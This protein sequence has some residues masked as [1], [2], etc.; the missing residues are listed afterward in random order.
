MTINRS[1]MEGSNTNQLYRKIL[2]GYDGSENANRALGRA[3]ELVIFFRFG[4]K[5]LSE[6][7]PPLTDTRFYFLVFF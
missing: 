3:I 6:I 4:T 5:L 7:I 2:V 1:T